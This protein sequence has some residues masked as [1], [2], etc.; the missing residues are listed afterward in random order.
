MTPR[1]PKTDEQKFEEWA[2]RTAKAHVKNG[3][4]DGVIFIRRGADDPVIKAIN[5]VFKKAARRKI[6]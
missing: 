5:E 4:N 6:N 1:S 3:G 2:T